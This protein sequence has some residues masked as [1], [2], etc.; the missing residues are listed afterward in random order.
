MLVVDGAY[1]FLGARDLVNKTN[2]KLI[3]TEDKIKMIDDYI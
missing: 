2:R 1:V 3:L